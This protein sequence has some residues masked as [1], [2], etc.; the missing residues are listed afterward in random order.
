MILCHSHL[1]LLDAIRLANRWPCRSQLDIHR[2]HKNRTSTLWRLQLW[3]PQGARVAWGTQEGQE[4]RSSS[5]RY[6]SAVAQN[7]ILPDVPQ[8]NQN[9]ENSSNQWPPRL[10]KLPKVAR[11]RW[12]RRRG[13]LLEVVSFVS[14]VGSL[15]QKNCGSAEMLSRCGHWRYPGD[16][17]GGLCISWSLQCGNIFCCCWFS[18]IWHTLD[19][20]SL[21][22]ALFSTVSKKVP[23]FE[24]KIHFEIVNS[25]KSRGQQSARCW[26]WCV[27]YYHRLVVDRVSCLEAPLCKMKIGDQRQSQK[28]HSIISTLCPINVFRRSCGATVFSF[29]LQNQ[30]LMPSAG[31]LS[32][33]QYGSSFLY[34]M[35]VVATRTR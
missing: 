23:Q 2:T 5:V 18:I 14:Q 12:G 20:P 8:C 27:H 19:L 26:R 16:H 3:H 1:S 29:V 28:L 15:S 4:H 21:A 33:Q 10:P 9:W 11:T 7:A 24:T 6:T 13:W 32:T 35:V 17:S 22:H 25:L 30:T 31:Q 34:R